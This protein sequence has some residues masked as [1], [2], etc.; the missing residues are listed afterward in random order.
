MC[1]FVC[2]RVCVFVCAC[3]CLCVFCVRVCLYMCVFFACFCVF[4]RVCVCYC[5]C[6]CVCI[7]IQK[8]ITVFFLQN[9]FEFRARTLV[10]FIACVETDISSAS[11][12][13]VCKL[14]ENAEMLNES[15]CRD[16]KCQ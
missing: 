7:C 5:I 3:V 16:D 14:P 9:E 11:S 2:V 4:V 8:Y 1:V 12:S 6:V 13:G 15:D 10:Q